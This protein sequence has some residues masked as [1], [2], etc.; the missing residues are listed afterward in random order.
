MLC[1]GRRPVWWSGWSERSRGAVLIEILIA[2]AILGVISTVFIGAMYTSLH[3]AR[4]TDERSTAVTLARTQIE[5]VK[6]QRV[7]AT[8]DWDY[9]I[10]TAGWT[11]TTP[12]SWLAGKPSTYII[13]QAEYSGYSVA[14]T[15]DSDPPSPYKIWE[16]ESMRLITATVRHEGATVFTLNNYQLDRYFPE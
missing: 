10:T 3:A 16:G 1:R 5:F 12:P 2:L 8:S 4:L 7:Y 15:G 6:G 9:T 14:V 13:L 11:A